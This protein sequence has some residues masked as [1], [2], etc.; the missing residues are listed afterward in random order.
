MKE[1]LV[2]I[3][4]TVKNSKDTIEK[5]VK[6]LLGLDYK[7]YKIFITDA[8]STDGTYEI[9]EKFRKKYSKKILLEQIKGNAP[10]AFNYMIKKV[11]TPFIAMTDADCVVDKN[12]LKNLIKGF[13]SSE[14]V[15]TAGFC[16]TPKDVNLLQ[17]LI[18]RELEDRFKKASKVKILLHAPTMNLCIRTAIAKKVKMDERLDVA[19]ET[20]WGLRISKFGKIKYVPEAKVYHYHRPT[21]KSYY[22]QQFKQATFTPAVYLKDWKIFLQN[23]LCAQKDTISNP[24]MT[25]QINLCALSILFLIL[26]FFNSLFAFFSLFFFLI[27]VFILAK[28]AIRLGENLREIFLLFL[29]FFIRVPVWLFGIIK[30]ILK[31][32]IVR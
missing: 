22:K 13:D 26:S 18:G 29:I 11:K 9:L 3:L 14:T 23:F 27:L 12:W 25:L 30:G 1:P 2:T 4:V 20:D 16:G 7:N 6:S 31:L 32:L 28:E 19:F 10:K 17:K 15:M 5:C 24:L 21:L 8:F